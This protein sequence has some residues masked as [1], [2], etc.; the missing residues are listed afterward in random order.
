M[1]CF[2]AQKDYKFNLVL[3][4]DRKY[5]FTYKGGQ[6]C[7]QL[8]NDTVKLFNFNHEEEMEYFGFR[9]V[10]T[11]SHVQWLNLNK[12][13]QSQFKS[14]LTFSNEIIVY[15]SVK[16]YQPD[17]CKLNETTRYLFYLQ[18][19]KDILLG[20][21]PVQFDYAVDLFSYFIQ[22][23]LGEYNSSRDTHGYSSEFEFMP[24]Q[25]L[26]LEEAVERKH[27][28]LKGMTQATAE[29]NFLNKAK[30]LEMYGVDLQPALG[31]DN[32]EYFIGLTPTG[33][34]V[35]QN[36]IKINSYFW[37]RISK[38][39]YKENRFVLTVI[40]DT[41]EERSRIFVLDNKLLCKNLW[42][43]CVDHHRFFRIKTVYIEPAKIITAVVT[44]KRKSTYEGSNKAPINRIPTKRV[45]RRNADPFNKINE[46][47]IIIDVNK[48]CITEKINENE[49]LIFK[50]VDNL[51]NQAGLFGP[52]A[53]TTEIPN[54]ADKKTSPTA[55]TKSIN[56]YKFQNPRRESVS[57]AEF[58]G[59]R[60]HGSRN[61]SRTRRNKDENTQKTDSE[62]NET[63][64]KP[65]SKGKENKENEESS[66]RTSGRHNRRR[67]NHRSHSR[68]SV[69]NS[70]LAHQK[71]DAKN[72]KSRKSLTDHTSGAKLICQ[73]YNTY[74]AQQQ[75][76]GNPSCHET[77]ID[78]NDINEMEKKRQVRRR[79]RSK[80]PGA[81]TKPPEEILQHIKYKLTEQTGL[82]ADQLKEIPFVK[83]ETSAAP[84]RISPHQ[85]H[86]RYS[87]GR[88]RS[89]E[90]RDSKSDVAYLSNGTAH[91]KKTKNKFMENLDSVV[92]V[93][94]VSSNPVSMGSAVNTKLT[95]YTEPGA[96]TNF[97]YVNFG[98]PSVNIGFSADSGCEDMI[99]KQN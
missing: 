13:V 58:G 3:L 62:E 51:S 98:E 49:N 7:Q 72:Y 15:F 99:I 28:K 12:T 35:Y 83:I 78:E 5:Q 92:P 46:D 93:P 27:T 50:P 61:R 59:R 30:W 42:K 65:I 43:Y 4:D 21:L 96:T 14:F 2:Q 97:G 37:P 36:K 22:N 40:E 25:S 11:N 54:L 86:R 70:N 75:Y 41:S 16:Y 18:L 69:K 26:E 33:I 85:K 9:F 64:F 89:G 47:A 90:F 52:N 31:E 48:I 77:S 32:I 88:R 20:R 34:S 8:L 71:S 57:E 38:L 45:P 17:P 19:R 67:S 29:M 76:Y 1:L 44:N 68:G 74:K 79:K 87:P 53:N 23:E 39:N 82:N 95:S 81:T 56:S 24:N 63:L 84:F 66:R 91:I 60:R 10:D 94:T 73:D 6:S 55:S 80:S